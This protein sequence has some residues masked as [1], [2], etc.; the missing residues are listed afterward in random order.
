MGGNPFFIIDDLDE[1][2][3]QERIEEELDK[4]KC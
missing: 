1:E 3:Y 4:E 2:Q